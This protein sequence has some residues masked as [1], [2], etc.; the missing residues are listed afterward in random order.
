MEK[1][2]TILFEYL[3]TT[4]AATASA[5]ADAAT[6]PLTNASSMEYDGAAVDV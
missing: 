3:I 1:L 2:L 5:A 6:F 4:T